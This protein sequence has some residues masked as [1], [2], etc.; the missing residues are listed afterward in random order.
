M[1]SSSE[2]GTSAHGSE[3]TGVWGRA[4]SALQVS[5]SWARGVWSKAGAVVN[6]WAADAYDVLSPKVEL[7]TRSISMVVAADG[8][9]PFDA[10]DKAGDDSSDHNGIVRVNDLITYRVDYAV[11]GVHSTNT[12]VV[13]G[14]PKGLMIDE[15]PAFCGQGSSLVPASAGEVSLPYTANSIND[16]AEQT[17]SCNVGTKDAAAES[18]ALSVKVSNAVHNGVMLTPKSLIL[19][20]DNLADVSTAK[21]LP[22]V[23]SSS[24]LKWDLSMNG[25][26]ASEN[27]G[28]MWGP[29]IR[30]CPQDSSRNCFYAGLPLMMS[31]GA[32]GKGAM[33]AVEPVTMTLD[34]SPRQIFPGLTPQQYQS[35]EANPQKYGAV[36]ALFP[37]YMGGLPGDKMSRY[38]AEN[39]TRDSGTVVFSQPGGPGTATSITITNTD[40]SLKTYPTKNIIGETL[41][42]GQAYAI[43]IAI[44]VD[45]PVDTVK[46]FGIYNQGTWTLQQRKAYTNLHMQGFGGADVLTSAGQNLTNDY[47][48]FSSQVLVPGTFGVAFGGVPGDLQNSSPRDY[49]PGWWGQIDGLPG[50]STYGGG[51][52]RSVSG[53]KV[54]AQLLFG[55]SNSSY[56]VPV[57]HVAGESWD[58]SKL[59]LT[60]MTVAQIK[61]E[62]ILYGFPVNNQAV[63]LS[64]YGNPGEGNLDPSSA[65]KIQVEYANGPSPNSGGSSDPNEIGIQ[66]YDAPEKV[67]GNNPAKAASGIYT[68][69]NRIRIYVVLPEALPIVQLQ[70]FLAVQV[71]FTVAADGMP[72]NTILPTWASDYK[73]SGSVSKAEALTTGT[74]TISSYN[75]ATHSGF[76]AGD[77]LKLTH[78][79]VGVAS[80][81]RKG[82]SGLFVPQ[83]AATGG[84]VVEFELRAS[85]TSAGG[86]DPVGHSVWLEDCL[87][88]ALEYVPSD[89]RGGG[90]R[91]V[92]SV[93]QSSTPSDAKRPACGVGETYVRWVFDNQVVND[94]VPVVV[95]AA[96]VSGAA[97]DGTYANSVVAWSDADQSSLVDRTSTVAVRV[98]NI[99]GVAVDKRNLTATVEVNRIGAKQ[100]E[101]NIWELSLRNSQPT[102]GGLTNP[103]VVDVLPVSGVAGSSFSGSAKLKSV[104]VIRGDLPGNPVVVEYT[105]SSS[106]P[107][108]PKVVMPASVKWCSQSQLGSAGCPATVADTKA[109]RLSRPGVF[110][111]GESISATVAVDVVGDKAGDTVS[112][113]GYAR[114]TGLKDPVGPVNRVQKIVGSSLSGQAWWDLDGGGVRDVGEPVVAGLPVRVSGSDDLGNAV[115]VSV[116]TDAAGMYTFADMRS[117]SYRVSVDKG[118]SVGFTKQ[119]QGSDRAI[120][121]DVDANGV[122]N[123]TLP[124]GGVED[125]SSDAGLLTGSLSWSKVTGPTADGVK[126]LSGSQWK[127]TNTSGGAVSDVTGTSLGLVVDCDTSGVCQAGQ[128][129][130][131]PAKAGF[132]VRYLPAGSYVLTETKA[133]PGY[134]ADVKEYAFTIDATNASVDLGRIVNVQQRM[135]G[136]PLTGGVSVMAYL[137]LGLA[138]L[139][140]AS[141]FGVSRS[142]RLLAALTRGR[143]Q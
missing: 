88:A 64:G 135:P 44:A 96:R 69:V 133:P 75:Q 113:E 58:N 32:N 122:A 28:Y 117:G 73:L 1:Q 82:S 50:L 43:A 77:R 124:V 15:L 126:P 37:D 97:D 128:V 40:W 127:I 98:D 8:T 110:A 18:F 61:R 120:D 53:Q 30:Q 19:K 78:A 136:L 129:D 39:S 138:F 99:I 118:K 33:P 35:L 101:S 56:P 48:T 81:V 66:W 51:E 25:V 141:L 31:A 22:S 87:P 109:V 7:G 100:V 16:L 132:K 71:G 67:P 46:D 42:A 92:P 63:W 12:T 104:T 93:V 80:G 55:G 49:N 142:R 20:G 62:G 134:V 74:P 57:T 38:G 47:R 112:N 60:K 36:S 107:R 4:Q 116:N 41:P 114:I 34:L 85:L 83:V 27:T 70:V 24:S 2:Q 59:H 102:S 14:L 103:V 76:R 140:G 3:L 52:N 10:T 13:I 123:V 105:S 90:T 89:G 9:A 115:D 17:I 45:V 6:R 143:H 26:T 111:S 11:S 68:G 106:V 65:P 79:Q 84:D 94:P 21:P 108:D 139:L 95:L 131:D 5:S 130:V 121:S 137:L 72:D 29:R 91:P 54:V 86:A 23:R 125:S 119:S